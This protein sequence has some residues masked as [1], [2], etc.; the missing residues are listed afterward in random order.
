MEKQT[1]KVG[2]RV[3]VWDVLPV[4]EEY[5]YEIPDCYIEGRITSINEQKLEISVYKD[6]VYEGMVR[7]R[8][9]TPLPGYAKDDWKTRI[10]ILP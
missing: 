1:L 10:E 5:K 2:D 4:P 9:Y 6:S 3:R 7:S 8:I